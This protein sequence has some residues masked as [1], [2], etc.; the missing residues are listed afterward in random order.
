MSNKGKKPIYVS[1]KLTFQRKNNYLIVS[2][3][4]PLL[5]NPKLVGV[6]NTANLK[7]LLAL[8]AKLPSS[9]VLPKVTLCK[10]P[11]SGLQC[12]TYSLTTKK[13]LSNSV[14]LLK[15]MKSSWGTLRTLLY[16]TI[17]GLYKLHTIKFKLVG[18]GYKANLKKKP[19]YFKAG[20]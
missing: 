8:P 4:T 6:E 16:N 11:K 19:F 13:H 14:I 2:N 9:V 12:L 1:S 17:Q 7:V 10:E 15:K 5:S 3:L 20:V 18:V